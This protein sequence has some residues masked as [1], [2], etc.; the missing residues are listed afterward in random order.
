MTTR[1]D[2]ITGAN[3]GGPHQLPMRRRWAARVAQF[4]RQAVLSAPSNK[5]HYM[6]I[7]RASLASSFFAVFLLGTAA[8]EVANIPAIGPHQPFLIVEKNVHPQN[9]MVLYTKVDGN[10]RFLRDPAARNRP[11][12]D[13]YW[14][15]D[16]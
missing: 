11:V 15:I 16:G 12:F 5:K 13:F 9:R 10:G 7:L 6:P 8:G 1:A 4:H 14:L 2:K 3:A